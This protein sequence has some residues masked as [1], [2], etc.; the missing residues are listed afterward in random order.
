M[1]TRP[2]KEIP[3]ENSFASTPYT[4]LWSKL[5]TLRPNEVCKGSAEHHLFK[6]IDC[7]HY[8]DAQVRYVTMGKG[9]PYCH[10]K[11]LCDSFCE[12]C[13]EKS[14]AS[15]EH[16]PRWSDQ[17]EVEPH[18]VFKYSDKKY[19]FECNDCDHIYTAVLNRVSYG[20]SCLYCSGNLLCGDPECEMCKKRSV[21]SYKKGH[22][23]SKKNKINPLTIFKSSNTKFYFDCDVC[24]HRFFRSPNHI[25]PDSFCGYCAGKKICKDLS[26]LMC[27]ERSFV[28]EPMA[29]YWDPVNKITPREVFKGSDD[30]YTFNCDVCKHVF[31]MRLASISS[32]KCGCPYCGR[33]R[34]CNDVNCDHCV[35]NSFL[36]SPAHIYWSKN[37]KKKPRDVAKFS[38][39]KYEFDCPYCNCVYISAASNVS[40]GK[41][42]TCTKNKTET[43]LYEFLV[44]NYPNLEIIKEKKFDWC[45]N[46]RHL[47]FDIFIKKYNLIIELD[48][49]Q[50]FKYIPTWGSAHGKIQKK[51]VKKM[52]LANQHNYSVIRI[53]QEDVWNEKHNWKKNLLKVIK[54]YADPINIFVGTIYS[55]HPK[56]KSTYDK[57]DSSDSSSYEW[58]SGSESS[59]CDEWSSREHTLYDGYDSSS[60]DDAVI[61]I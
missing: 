3:F 51:D 13:H 14:F 2:K 15:S 10:N 60:S 37:N 11:K 21:V 50:H 4:H 48:G 5:N 33:R 28:S 23:W 45:K 32:K 18:T 38:N 9:C 12:I 56:Y 54:K 17:N 39:T 49:D 16:A 55:L 7:K 43:K 44:S 30:K 42:C 24:H 53:Y 59:S 1:S 58:S 46:I 29:K 20:Q 6:C 34:L 57:S 25:S 52:K 26:C 35:K 8:F 27:E 61:E 19:L 22:C 31:D 36:S 41:W 40:K 47:P